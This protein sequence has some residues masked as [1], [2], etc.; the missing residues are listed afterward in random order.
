MRS[1]YFIA[2]FLLLQ[3]LLS[4]REGERA[5]KRERDEI[6]VEKRVYL[7]VISGVH[8]F[9]GLDC[10]QESLSECTGLKGS[11]GRASKVFT[12]YEIV[13]KKYG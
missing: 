9:F 4:C 8:L 12:F 7:F 11:L 13:F 1:S 6:R 2:A 10:V 5:K 3:L